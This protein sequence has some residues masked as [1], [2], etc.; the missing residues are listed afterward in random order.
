MFINLH[1]IEDKRRECSPITS[2]GIK[3]SNVVLT[4][5]L[6]R[7]FMSSA[8]IKIRTKKHIAHFV[9][10][11]NTGP[12]ETYNFRQELLYGFRLPEKILN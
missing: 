12:G 8:E 3:V 9:R 1:K 11:S 6:V 4:G 2:Q 7:I 5:E 10:I